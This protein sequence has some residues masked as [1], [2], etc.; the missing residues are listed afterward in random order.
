MLASIAW[1][2][3]WRNPVRSLV[4]IAAIAIGVWAAMFMSGFATGMANGYINNTI[5]EVVSHL[6]AHNPQFL[7]DNEAQYTL[8]EGLERAEALASMP[9]VKALSARTIVNGMIASG[10]GARGIRIRGVDP[11][12]EAAVSPIAGK[13]V[14]GDYLGAGQRNPILV[15]TALAEK[16]GVKLRSRLVLTFQDENKEIISAAFRVSGIF[17][18]SNKLLDESIVYVNRTDINDLL[19]P[20]ANHF[21]HELAILLHD[22]K[23]TSAFKTSLQNR[24]P[25]WTVRTYGEISPDLQLYESQ[26]NSVSLIYLV[27]IMLALVFGII[28]TMLMA[29]LE[30]VRELGMLMAVGMNKLR[31]F[32]MIVLETCFLGL[33]GGPAGLALGAITIAWLKNHGINMSMFSESL[34]MYGMSEIVYF[35]V[36][37][38]IYWQVPL[39]VALTALVASLY[40]A[41]KAIRLRPVEAIRKI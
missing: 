4:V 7:K 5:A 11:G 18:S 36:Q 20:G 27:V 25:D 38:V 33:I 23:Q 30:R 39:M 2:N 14:E 21:A 29:V 37:P 13:I 3:I 15:S 31:V 12:A 22:P 24:F 16:L 6:Q 41:W 8:T 10:K 9:E 1:R 19:K 32:L 34:R 40:P 26:I 35:D 28:N 17:K